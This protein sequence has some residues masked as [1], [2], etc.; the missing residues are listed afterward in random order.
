MQKWRNTLI[1]GALTAGIA[2]YVFLVEN[3]RDYQP[4]QEETV[5]VWTLSD[6][7]MEDIRTIEVAAGGKSMR[8]VRKD[9]QPTPKASPDV[10]PDPL[11][12]PA[13]PTW[14]AEGKLDR[15]LT[16]EWD[17][18]YTD[19][20]RPVA[21][22]VVDEAPKDLTEYELSSPSVEV[23]LLDGK[24]KVAHGMQFG[25]KAISGQGNYVKAVDG[26]KVYLI[27][28][29]KLDTIRKLVDQPPVA[30]PAP[31]PAPTPSPSPAAAASPAA[32]SAPASK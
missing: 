15:G 26:S 29:H 10:T 6:R 12:T 7:Q 4:G 9:P 17:N 22:R 31:T 11:A 28:S 5:A 8:Y 18:A 20:K 16:Y 1:L 24:G 23:R 30:S 27:A 21:V 13:Q 32:T 3:K 2:A 19:I 25:K 14:H